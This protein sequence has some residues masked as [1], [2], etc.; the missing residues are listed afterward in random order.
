[1]PEKR[2]RRDWDYEYKVCENGDGTQGTTG[3]DDGENK[4]KGLRIKKRK[5]TEDAK[6]ANPSAL[7]TENERWDAGPSAIV[8]RL[9]GLD[10]TNLYYNKFLGNWNKR[11]GKAVYLSKHLLLKLSTC[12][13]TFNFEIFKLIYI[14]KYPHVIKS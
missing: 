3:G 14:I 12:Y 1:M 11:H 5:Q 9:N 7:S 2:K 10:S 8:A 13:E 4:S 6:E